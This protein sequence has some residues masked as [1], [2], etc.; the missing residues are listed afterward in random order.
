[1]H[2]LVRPFLLL[3]KEVEKLA[4]NFR[5]SKHFDEQRKTILNENHTSKRGRRRGH[6]SRADDNHL[7]KIGKRRRAAPN[8]HALVTAKRPEDVPPSGPGF[9]CVT[10]FRSPTRSRFP[11]PRPISSKW[12][13]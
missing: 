13:R 3:H 2:L 12:R 8:P 4:T 5:S 7:K 10:R 1:M 9:Q 6:E 11:H